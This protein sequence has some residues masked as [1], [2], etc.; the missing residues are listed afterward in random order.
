MNDHILRAHFALGRVGA[1]TYMPQ[2]HCHPDTPSPPHTVHDSRGLLPSTALS[3]KL[4][5]AQSWCTLC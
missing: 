1:D 3:A 5:E 2:P 4:T